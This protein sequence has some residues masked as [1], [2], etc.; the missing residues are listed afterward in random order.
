M[1]GNVLYYGD[2]LDVLRRYVPDLSVD[3]VY[4]DPP[5]NSNADYNAFFAE[6]DG[7]RAA[8]QIKAFK[9]TWTW[10][11][12]S[13][14]AYHEFVVA[15]RTPER[16]RKALIA[17]RDLL[18]GSDM[19]A[20]LAMMAPRLV[21][22]HRV[23]KPT[24][25]LYLHCDPTASHYLKLILDSVFGPENFKNEIVWRRT[26][27]HNSAKRYGPIHDTIFYYVKSKNFYFKKI[28][29]PYSLGHVRSYFKKSDARGNY[30]SNALTGA[31]TRN[32]DSGK[33]WRTYDPTSVGRHWAVPGKVVAALGLD[34]CSSIQ[35][36]L[37]LLDAAGYIDHPAEKSKAMPTYRQ[38]LEG[39]PGIAIQDIWSYQPHTQGTLYGTE[40]GIDEDVRWMT[41]QGDPEKL[42]YPTQKPRGLLERIIA[43]SCP[44]NGLVLDP[45]CGCGTTIE[46]AQKLGRKWIGIDITQLSIALIKK[47]LHDAFEGKADKDYKTIGEP[48]TAEDAARL[49]KDDPY[50]F[51]WW[52]LGLC[53][54]RPVEQKKGADKGIDGRLYF[55]DDAE[56]TKPKQVI[57]SVKAGGTTVSQLRG[58]IDREK[59][60][61]GVM[62]T[63]A[64]PTAPMRAEAAGAGFYTS[65]WDNKP[66]PKLQL[67]TVSDLLAGQGVELP[68]TG[69]M[70]TFKKAPKSAKPNGETQL[71]AFED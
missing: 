60:D 46:A 11:E 20:Y 61:I 1:S 15:Q 43:S 22:L 23:L 9:D 48:T 31:G 62:V 57:F 53:G 8:S 39:S 63:M 45:F 70:R 21:E 66:Y 69:D 4:L 58:V 35:E 16:A 41:K 32:G 33:A 49:A 27:S 25:S 14:R 12:A 54:A 38:Y 44:E 64:E 34:D 71:K 29:S 17:F 6:Q 55:H 24:G 19:M 50:Q 56:S 37:D 68:P 42:D 2:N 26:G 5:F 47:R 18:G 65:P 36:R 28:Y 51:L 59:A 67:R 7:S 40:V 3:L 13:S 52:A 10:D 30:W